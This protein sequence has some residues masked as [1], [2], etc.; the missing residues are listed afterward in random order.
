MYSAKVGT[1]VSSR[2]WG[3][4]GWSSSGPDPDPAPG[5]TEATAAA[6]A[7]ASHLVSTCV[8][9]P[10][11]AGPVE[12]GPPFPNAAHEASRRGARAGPTTTTTTCIMSSALFLFF[13]DLTLPALYL[14]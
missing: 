13:F 6:A 3:Y 9:A 5:R 1:H 11:R 4:E 14:P 12:K 10:H 2:L 8:R 7:A